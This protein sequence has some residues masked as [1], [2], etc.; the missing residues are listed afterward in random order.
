MISLKTFEKIHNQ[1]VSGLN[2]LFSYYPNSGFSYKDGYLQFE[3]IG[4]QSVIILDKDIER[5]RSIGW[6]KDKEFTNN[7]WV[8]PV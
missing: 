8:H 2:I 1:L 6:F 3:I 4:E 5:L 7:N